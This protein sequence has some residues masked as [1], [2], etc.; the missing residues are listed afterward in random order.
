[1]GLNLLPPSFPKGLNSAYMRNSHPFSPFVFTQI[2]RPEFRPLPISA[3]QALRPVPP[4]RLPIGQFHTVPKNSDML[5]RSDL[6]G[7]GNYSCNHPP[8]LFFCSI[9]YLNNTTDALH[10][11]IYLYKSFRA[12]VISIHFLVFQ[13]SSLLETRTNL[14]LKCLEPRLMHPFNT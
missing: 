6:S 9:A 8:S 5:T 4:R 11:G 3:S 12:K 2:R 10:S 7:S 14:F 13:D 1:M